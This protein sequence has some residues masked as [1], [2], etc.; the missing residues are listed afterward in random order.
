MMPGTPTGLFTDLYEFAMAQSYL[1]HGMLGEASFDLHFRELPSNRGYAV[2]AG[3]DHAL[4]R[5]DRFRFDEGMLSFLEDQ[6]FS[7]D[8]LD[9]LGGLRLAD[10]VEVRGIPEGRVVFPYEPVLEVT[11]PLPW[12]QLAETVLL[13]AVHLGMVVASKA[14]RCWYAACL[15]DGEVPALVDFGA[16]RAHG[17][18]AALEASRAAYMTGFEGT[19]LVEAARAFGIPCFGTMAHSYVQAFDS[20][21][22][23]LEA[24][25]SSFPEGT[26]LLVDT[27]DTLQGVERACDV[28]R[29]LADEGGSLGG[30]RLDSGDLGALARGVRDRL[31]AWGLED[32]SVFVSG[33]L[34]EDG[35]ASLVEE[36]AP[37]DGF[38][39]GSRLVTG[40]G[41][42][43]WDLVYKLVVYEREPVTKLSEGKR[44]L[45]GRKQVFRRRDEG[46]RLVGD[47]LVALGEEGD[48]EA[49][50]VPLDPSA[51]GGRL[52]AARERFLEEFEMLPD[53]FKALEDPAVYDVERSEG[54]RSAE[55]EAVK[56]AGG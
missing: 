6:G 19:S 40:M 16:R 34:D 50:M 13:N 12:A 39:V 54:L 43:T 53:R 20:E 31:D 9:A 8:L 30:V 18:D 10:E 51:A 37:I 14:A 2:S 46:G 15:G 55:E 36:G 35:I 44:I 28:A 41:A 1:E 3:V 33:G 23:A 32:V 29:G 56:H 7:E 22:E 49:L 11:G 21:V 45:P 27:Y 47:V 38:G 25:A 5:L 17:V 48:G 24:F 52:E 4:E 26:T 42:V